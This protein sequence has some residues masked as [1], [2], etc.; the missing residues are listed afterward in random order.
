M[1]QNQKVLEHMKTRGHITRRDAY[2]DYEIQNLTARIA[3]L[4]SMGHNIVAK[5]MKHENTGKEYSRFTLV[6]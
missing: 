2:M 5:P 1:T 3:D 6:A 4:R